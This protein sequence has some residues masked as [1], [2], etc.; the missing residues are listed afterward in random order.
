[1]VTF[2]IGMA[3]LVIVPTQGSQ[4]DAAEAVR[5]IK[6]IRNTEASREG[7]IIPAAILFT[8]TNA[9]IE[10]RDLR[11]IRAQFTANGV[12]VMQTQ[13]VERA[14]Y[15]ALFSFGGTLHTL[16]PADVSGLA[17]ARLN[18]RIFTTRKSSACS[19]S[20]KARS[21]RR[22]RMNKRANIFDDAAELDLSGFKPGARGALASEPTGRLGRLGSLQ[23][24]EPSGA[25]GAARARAAPPPHWPQC[26]AQ[27][28]GHRRYGCRL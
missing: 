13:V 5:A 17:M 7:L 1:M 27:H 12:P 10:T 4:L 19:R 8:R 24:P 28:Q 6:L 15:R 3:N 2:A 14:A 22:L 11:E 25:Q 21:V 20:S 18:A 26:A 9:A 23:F 16:D